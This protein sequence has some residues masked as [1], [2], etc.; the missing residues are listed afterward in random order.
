MLMLFIAYI[1]SGSYPHPSVC[2]LATTL[3][4]ISFLQFSQ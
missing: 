4:S 3:L 1:F 2:G